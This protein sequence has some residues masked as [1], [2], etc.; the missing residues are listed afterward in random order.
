MNR[1]K[2][3]TINE[4]IW[5]NKFVSGSQ[6]TIWNNYLISNN[7]FFISDF[8]DNSGNILSYEQFMS[9][10]SLDALSFSKSDYLPTKMTIKCFHNPN[11][12]TKSISNLDHDPSLPSAILFH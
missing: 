9:K 12:P 1:V 10:N 2:Q 4:I 6:N 11:N 5:G 7:V 8:I 3:K